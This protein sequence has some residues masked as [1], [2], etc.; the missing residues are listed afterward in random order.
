M[1]V[2]FIEILQ[3]KMK[4]LNV[5]KKIKKKKTIVIKAKFFSLFFFCVSP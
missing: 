5:L 2:E 4:L 1:V 3:K